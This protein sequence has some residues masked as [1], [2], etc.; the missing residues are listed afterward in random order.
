MPTKN[1]GPWVHGTEWYYWVPGYGYQPSQQGCPVGTIAIWGGGSNIPVNWILCEGQGVSTTGFAKLFSAIGYT[2]GG[3]GGTFYL[4]PAGVF[5][6]N[7]PG[8]VRD[9]RV[10]GSGSSGLN[11]RGGSQTALIPTD[12]MPALQVQL[13]YLNPEMIDNNVFVENTQAAGP[14][15]YYY[16]VTDEAG[17]ILGTNQKTIAIMPPFAAANFVIKYA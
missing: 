9:S 11:V 2:W 16:P 12:A 14:S 8:F 7:A 10:P 4:P 13:Q 15:G 17:N 3:S 6:L 1:I 5:F